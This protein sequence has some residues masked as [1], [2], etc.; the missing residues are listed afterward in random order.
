VSS[1]KT[2]PVERDFSGTQSTQSPSQEVTDRLAGLLPGE[3]LE[4]A[5]VGL[6]P[7][8]ITG[9]GGVL[10]QLAGRVIETAWAPS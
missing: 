6:E 8:Q 1:Q 2:K 5:L 9:P 7:D 3:D 10:S 4:K